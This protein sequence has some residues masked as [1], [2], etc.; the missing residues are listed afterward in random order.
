[1]FAYGWVLLLKTSVPVTGAAETPCSS[2]KEETSKV[3][4]VK[5][6]MFV[7]FFSAVHTD[8][9][10]CRKRKKFLFFGFAV[11]VFGY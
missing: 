5:K 1:M 9:E 2:N 8:C 7:F 4:M 11:S 3:L 6:N 10:V